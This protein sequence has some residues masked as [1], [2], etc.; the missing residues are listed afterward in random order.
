MAACGRS[1]ESEK[2]IAIPL[3]QRTAIRLREPWSRALEASVDRLIL[4]ATTSGSIQKAHAP[5]KIRAKIGPAENGKGRRCIFLES[6]TAYDRMLPSWLSIS[7]AGSRLQARFG[8]KVSCIYSRHDVEPRIKRSTEF[9]ATEDEPRS[10][11]RALGTQ[12][13]VLRPYTRGRG[14]AKLGSQATVRRVHA[15]LGW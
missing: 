8:G 1:K 11:A 4:Q 15:A 10:Y 3:H 9:A 5:Q 7:S 14:Q 6:L 2:S 13:V 12:R